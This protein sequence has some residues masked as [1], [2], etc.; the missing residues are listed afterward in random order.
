MT[1][2]IL[3]M[4]KLRLSKM[5]RNSLELPGSTEQNQNSDPVGPI[6][7]CFPPQLTVFWKSAKLQKLPAGRAGAGPSVW[8]VG[9]SLKLGKS[10]QLLE[11]I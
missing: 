9:W 2:P 6:P 10:M 7:K 8:N 4:R 11:T 1:H 5:K 3:E